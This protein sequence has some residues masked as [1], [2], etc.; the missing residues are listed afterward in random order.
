LCILGISGAGITHL[1]TPN[2]FRVEAKLGSVFIGEDITVAQGFFVEFILTFILTIV[3]LSCKDNK[4]KHSDGPSSI[5]IGVT[6][7]ALHF[8][9]KGYTGGSFN[10]ARAFGPSLIFGELGSYSWI[11]WIAPYVGSTIAGLLYRFILSPIEPVKTPTPS[12]DHVKI[13]MPDL[14]SSTGNEVASFEILKQSEFRKGFRDHLNCV[15]KIQLTQ[16]SLFIVVQ[17]YETLKGESTLACFFNPTHVLKI[18]SGWL[19]WL[20]TL[21]KVPF[22][23]WVRRILSNER[24]VGLFCLLAIHNSIVRMQCLKNSIMGVKEYFREF[25]SKYFWRAVFCE[26]LATTFFVFI[27]TSVGMNFGKT[28][29]MSIETIKTCLPTGFTMI[30]LLKTFGPISGGYVNPALSMGAYVNGDISSPRATMYSVAQY[31]GGLFGGGITHF[32]TPYKFRLESKLGSVFIGEDITVAQGFFVEFILTFILT[33]VFLSCKDN[34]RKHSDGPSTIVVGVTYI[35]LHFAGKG[36]TGGS[37]NPARAFGPSLIFGEWDDHSW[38][39]WVAPYV[40]S[41]IAGLLYRFILSPIEPVETDSTNND[42]VKI[43]MTEGTQPSYK[44][45]TVLKVEY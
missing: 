38:I 20:G 42:H 23:D 41:T 26:L 14:T 40:G 4:R 3:F 1:L 2:K 30:F 39:Y 16:L 5:I 22:V 9:G 11:Y 25:N 34:K 17:M 36:Y 31:V 12:K 43:E 24:S 44:S 7:I 8:A 28:F 37:F 35:G 10:P 33:L 32:L 21:K 29:E 27:V 15:I 18:L 19:T 6:Y 45:N 13:E